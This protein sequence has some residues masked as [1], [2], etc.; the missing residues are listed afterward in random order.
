MAGIGG[1]DLPLAIPAHCIGSWAV[2]ALERAYGERVVPAA[3]GKF[4]TLDG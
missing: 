1:F 3:V 2:N 4:F